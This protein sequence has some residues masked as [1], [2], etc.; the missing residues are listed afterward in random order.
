M[1]AEKRVRYGAKENARLHKMLEQHKEDQKLW[2]NGTIT[3]N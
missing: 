3:R 2:D 1:K